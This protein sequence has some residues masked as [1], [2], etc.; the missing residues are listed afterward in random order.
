MIGGS[1]WSLA[2]LHNIVLFQ[3][4]ETGAVWPMAYDFDWT[5]IVWTRY[6]FPDS[7]LPIK[8]V[9]ERLYRGICLTPQEWAPILSRFQDKKS[10]LYAVYDSLPDLD[11]KYVRETREYLDEFF[12][13]ISDP[14]RMKREM[15]DTCRPGA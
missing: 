6:S 1:D 15:I 7:R 9:R 12:E 8:S 13:V 10:A 3:H 4:R 2:A 5:G 14:R 11:P